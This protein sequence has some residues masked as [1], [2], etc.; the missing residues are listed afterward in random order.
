MAANNKYETLCGML[1]F[2][3]FGLIVETTFTGCAAFWDGSFKG[4]VSLLM[5]PVYSL[6]YV[7]GIYTLPYIEKTVIFKPVFRLP[8]IVIV[9]YSIEWTFGA[10][11]KSIG[12]IPWHYDHGWASD[13]SNGNITLYF[14]PAWVLFS[15]IVI[16]VLKIIQEISPILI[17]KIESEIS[18]LNH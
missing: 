15:L 6:S 9:I 10:F 13:F 3:A 11:Y 14:L 4:G 17:T 16:P 12:L 2:S 18:P 7:L 5:I 1:L 8:I